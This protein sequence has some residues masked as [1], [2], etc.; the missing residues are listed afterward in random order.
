MRQIANR[1]RPRSRYKVDLAS[2]PLEQ[3]LQAACRHAKWRVTGCPICVSFFFFSFWPSP[4]PFRQRCNPPLLFCPSYPGRQTLNYGENGRPFDSRR[5]TN[6]SSNGGGRVGVLSA[7][8]SE[9]CHPTV[10]W[11]KWVPRYFPKLYFLD[12]AALALSSSHCPF[13]AQ[14]L[15]V[16]P[17][18]CANFRS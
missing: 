15:P 9:H 11:N 2:G 3:R 8:S 12:P 14:L 16:V 18:G 7:F 1:R 13:A 4:P 17:L 10:V 5:L 6:P